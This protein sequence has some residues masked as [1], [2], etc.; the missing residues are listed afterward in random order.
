MTILTE[1]HMKKFKEMVDV[2]THKFGTFAAVRPNKD[3]R[4]KMKSFVDSN[5]IGNPLADDQ[6]HITVAFSKAPIPNAKDD[7]PS[8]PLTA[9][10]KEWKV[11]PTILGTTGKCLVA[12][13]DSDE[14]QEHHKMLREKYKASYDSDVFFRW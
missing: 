8:F 1:R 4:K 9:K 7:T 13:V 11:F 6:Y 12:A 3:T 2:G 14:L 5:G 10:F